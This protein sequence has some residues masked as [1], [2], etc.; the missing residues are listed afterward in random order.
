METQSYQSQYTPKKCL[1]P[2]KEMKS[3]EGGNQGQAV[4]H[5]KGQKPLSG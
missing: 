1:C 4:G 2:I 5:W 3:E